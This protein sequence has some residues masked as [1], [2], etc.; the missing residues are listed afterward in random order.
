MTQVYTWEP[1]SAPLG[2]AVVA[3]GVFDG[4][5]IGHQTLIR[6][7]VFEARERGVGAVA[8]T[9]DRDPDQVVTPD[10]AAPQLLSLEDKIG[11]ISALDVDSVLVVPFCARLAETTAERFLD[12]VLTQALDP[13]AVVVG[14]D[15]RFGHHASGTVETLQVFGVKHGFE[16]FGHDLVASGGEPVTSTRIRALIAEGH[17]AEAST[18]LGRPHRLTGRVGHGRGEGAPL[19]GVPTANIRPAPHAAVPADGVYAGFA[20][21]EGRAHAA[22]ISVGVPPTFPQSEDSIEA[23]IIDW[24][25]DLY[26][27]DLTLEFVARLR[28][29]SAFATPQELTAAIQGD[30]AQSATLLNREP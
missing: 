21:H 30:I 6:D 18:L 7:A 27:T 8:L 17:V 24:E 2:S 16:V 22:A 14:R 23:H 25:G 11:F 3:I 9:F 13:K 4:V 1:D 15:F 20:T 12:D 26:N 10:T 19:L 28:S 29:Q 5:H